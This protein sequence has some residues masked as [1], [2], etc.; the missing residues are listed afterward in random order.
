MAYQNRIRELGFTWGARVQA[1]AFQDHL[2]EELGEAFLSTV[3]PAFAA[4]RMS[5]WIRFAR[6]NITACDMPVT[7]H[8]LLA[9]YLFGTRDEL[10]LSLKR[11][12]EEEMAICRP[13]TVEEGPKG[14]DESAALTPRVAHRLRIRNEL[15]RNPRTTIQDLWRKAYRVTSW[16][17]EHDRDV[18]G[19]ALDFD[20]R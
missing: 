7:R 13:R 2:I 19:N 8:L 20:G 1:K 12:S 16:L 5:L 10:A 18:T 17:Y 14:P 3:D 4:K 11:V 15:S 9:M 6:G